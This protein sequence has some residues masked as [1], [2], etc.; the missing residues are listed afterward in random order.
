MSVCVLKKS[1]IL[2]LFSVGYIADGL[3][4]SKHGGCFHGATVQEW[5][6]KSHYWRHFQ[7]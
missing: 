3:T 7:D 4:C 6:G 1:L 2:G 5:L